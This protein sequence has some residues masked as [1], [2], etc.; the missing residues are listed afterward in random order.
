MTYTDKVPTVPGWYWMRWGNYS[1]FVA[2]I[3]TDDERGPYTV[4]Q[5]DGKTRI[6][7]GEDANHS[8]SPEPLIEPQ[9]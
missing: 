1:G 8:Y 6:Y 3:F 5:G 9:S 2:Q 7:V 4:Y